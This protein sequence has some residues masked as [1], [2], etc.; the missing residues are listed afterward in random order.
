ML[1]PTK[2]TIEEGRAYL[3]DHFLRSKKGWPCVCCKQVVK[4]APK[5]FSPTLAGQ[6][7]LLA[8]YYSTTLTDPE[9]YLD[10]K[11][12]LATLGPKG[13]ILHK[14]KLT[15]N[16]TYEQLRWWKLIEAKGT[17][18]DGT[19]AK[20]L[21]RLTKL[22]FDVAAGR[23]T[24]QKKVHIFNGLCWDQWLEAADPSRLAKVGKTTVQGA[25]GRRTEQEIEDAVTSS[26]ASSE[27]PSR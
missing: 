23:E 25:L 21:Y 24:V 17:R 19:S 7:L 1:D 20:T 10:V 16:K 26:S 6:L 5:T 11:V 3:R 15:G 22:G 8:R 18:P 12:Y 14:M 4:L 13:S 9:I 27:A 2:A